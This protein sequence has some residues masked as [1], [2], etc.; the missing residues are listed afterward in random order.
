MPGMFNGMTSELI[1]DIFSHCFSHGFVTSGAGNGKTLLL[2]ERWW[3]CR[4]RNSLHFRWQF[5]LRS[6][7]RSHPSAEICSFCL[8]AE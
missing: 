1:V 3:K 4:E 5:P 7:G 8:L 6:D 2:R